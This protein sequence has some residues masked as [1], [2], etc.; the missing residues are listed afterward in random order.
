MAT[1]P[2]AVTSSG[3]EAVELAASV[4]LLLDPWESYAVGVIL[5]ERNDGRWSA[6]EAAL[7]VARQNGKG[8]IFEVIELAALFLLGERLILH[9]AHEFKTSQEAFLRI[10]TLIDGSDDLRRRVARIRTSHGEE[11]IELVTG[12]RL[13]FVARSRSS[14]R[15]FTVDRLMCDESQELPRAAMGALLPTMSA[16]PNPQ[17]VYALTVP[18]PKN[19]SEHIES[20]RDRGRRGGDP[21][22]AW[23][24]WSP[25]PT[26][27]DDSYDK[28]DLD[29]RRNW[30][31]GNPALGYRMTDETIARERGALGDEQ[32]AAERLSV[33]PGSTSSTVIKMARWAVLAGR[34]PDRPTPVAFA[35]AVSPDRKW[36]TIAMAGQR[37]DGHR[38]IQIVQTGRGSAW[39]P[40]RVDELVREWNPVTVA[41]NPASPAG[42]LIIELGQRKV[43]V[44]SLT[45]RDVGQAC[46]MFVD[47]VEAATIHHVDQPVLTIAL[48]AT[49]KKFVGRLWEWAPKDSTDIAPLEAA[50]FALFGLVSQPTKRTGKVW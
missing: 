45:G 4:G 35:V 11:G 36:S 23:L 26:G 46:G 24:E 14:G 48:A 42:A 16:L 5:A 32:F 2:P 3:P 37:G 50:T 25:K 40:A 27:P 33:W 7:L 43:P 28:V 18:S 22:L 39:V 29:D 9:S 21:T 44:M 30:T 8:A 20:V 38:Q 10:K 41:L 47:E 17:V 15:G 31:A 49:K 13:R 19:D 1:F 6:F 12:Q 34:E